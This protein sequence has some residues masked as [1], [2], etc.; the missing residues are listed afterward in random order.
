MK[1]KLIMMA[2]S[3][4]MLCPGRAYSQDR[5]HPFEL[6]FGGLDFNHTRTMISDF[7]RTGG[8]DYVFKLEEKLLN[9]GASL[10]AAY[11]INP[12]LYL[13]AQG[14]L[15]LARYND[16]GSMKQGR[17]VMVGPG[18]QFRPQVGKGWV[19]PYLRIGIN[20]YYKDFPTLYFG[21]F[22]GDI[23]KEAQWKAEDSWNKGYTFDSES[24]FPISAGIGIIGWLNGRIGIR[25]EG[26]YLKSLGSKG[27]NF[28]QGSVGLVFSLGGSRRKPAVVET[29]RVVEK[30]VE[31]EVVKE[32]PVEKIKEIY[33]EVPCE[34]T[35]AGLMENVTFDFDKADITPESESV[36]DEVAG[37]LASFPEER[38]MVSGYTDARG[39]DSYNDSLSTSRAKAVYDALVSRGVPESRLCY[40]GF[41]KRTAVIP[42]SADD[43]IRRGD[44]KVVLERVTWDPL[45]QYLKSNQ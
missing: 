44:R 1:E 19:E 21:N 29:E 35:L 33:K 17:S 39:S 7:H 27:A 18:L 3:I 43:D 9:G 6:G 24:Y 2:M 25:I 32:V 34:R 23:T 37:I 15:G 5:P 22:D 14:T 4:L 11:G 10:Y 12:W 36:L 26:D 45:W 20:Y 13:D 28:A 8:G 40:R 41:G 31:K 42:G 16:S 38:F 30:I